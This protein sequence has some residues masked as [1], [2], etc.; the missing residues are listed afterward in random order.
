M[1]KLELTLAMSMNPRSRAIIEGSIKPDGIVFRSTI[2]SPPD[3]FYRQLHNQEF[4]VSEMSMSS[5]LMVLAS[6]NT[7]WGGLPI[8]TTRHFFQ[9]W[10]WVRADAGISRPEDLKGKRVGVPEY[11]QTAA[12]WSRG[13]LQHEFG[14]APRDMEWYMERDEQRSHGG[15]VGFKPPADIKFQYIPADK[16]IGSMMMNDELDATLLYISTGPNLV[17]RSTISFQNNPKVR[18]LFPNR[19]AES[20]RYFKK[21]GIFPMNHGIVVRRSI[22][23]KHPWVAL[24]IFNAYRL[25]KEQ[26]LARTRELASTH[27]DLGLVPEGTAQ[28]LQVDPYP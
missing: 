24:N 18:P 23:E 25:A 5:L 27:V 9:N 8:F 21:T 12:L 22:Y 17:D 19:N 16:S 10:A 20:Q 1:A 6:G 3:I 4:D 28:G 26:V 7:D 13:I 2:A 14:V 15:A 11:Q